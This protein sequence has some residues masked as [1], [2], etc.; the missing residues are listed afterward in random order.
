MYAFIYYWALGS[1]QWTV[2]SGQL[3]VNSLISLTPP[4]EQFERGRL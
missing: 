4:I 2:D 3:T 1:G